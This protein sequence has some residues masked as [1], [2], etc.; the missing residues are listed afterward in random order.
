MLERSSL[1]RPR[2]NRPG[3]ARFALLGLS[4]ALLAFLPSMASADWQAGLDAFRA[5]DLDAAETAFRAVVESQPDWYGGHRMLGQTLLGAEPR[6]PEGIAALERALELAPQDVATRWELGKALSNAERHER[7]RTVLAG[8]RPEGLPDTQWQTWLIY[9]AEAARQQGDSKAART[10][11]RAL[12]EL[13]GADAK[14][15]LVLAHLESR[16]GDENRALRRFTEARKAAKP[17]SSTEKD[18]LR[19]ELKLRHHRATDRS[20]GVG[21]G[22]EA[23]AALLSSTERLLT[24]DRSAENLSLAGRIAI[25]AERSEKALSWLTAAADAGA[26]DWRTHYSLGRQLAFADRRDEAEAVLRELLAGQLSSQDSGTTHDFL[27][28]LLEIDGRY[29][30]AIS[31]YGLAGS[32]EKVAAATHSRQIHRDNLEAEAEARRLEELERRL[33]ELEQEANDLDRGKVDLDEEEEPVS[34]EPSAT[35]PKKRASGAS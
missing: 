34:G 15:L 35:D 33:R 17:G 32:N 6:S 2:P 28:Y 14:T 29:D 9:R 20:A 12:A 24:L 19:V 16:L 10:D 4:L 3:P 25:C 22:A 21:D 31:Q 26:E 7:A 1:T 30:E 23:C 5:G 8:P 11:L 27:G 18:A 13:G